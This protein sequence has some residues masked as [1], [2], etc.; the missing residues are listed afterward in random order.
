MDDR[1]AEELEVKLARVRAYMRERGLD[2]LVLRRFDNF[3]WVT[4]GGDNRCAG[5]T[6]VGV[7]SVLVTP[8]DQCVLTSSVEGRRF[9]EEVLA[10]IWAGDVFRMYEY[11]WH[12]E[13]G[14]LMEAADRAL[15]PGGRIGSDVPLAGAE[16]VGPELERLRYPFTRGE[17]ERYVGVARGVAEIVEHAA[18][19]VRPGQTERAIAG[20]V[21]SDLVA[22]GY[23]PTVL[24][25]GADWRVER[26][27]HPLPTMNRVEKYCMIIVCAHRGGLT[28]ALTRSVHI[29]EPG[30]ELR[31]RHEAAAHICAAMNCRTQAGARWADVM[32]AMEEEYRAQGFEGEWRNHHQGGPIGYQDRE[33]LVTPAEVSDWDFGLIRPLQAVAWNPSVPG[34]KSEDSLLVTDAGPEIATFG[35]GWWPMI[36]IEVEGARL[37][38]P[39]ILIV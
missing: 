26:Y 4:A 35:A 12:G 36:D 6:D 29:G 31:R 9:R 39:D 34:A 27:R 32:E 20:H 15:P 23:F 33:F 37:Q 2:A 11:P 21:G 8:D 30:R 14:A 19:E 28:A 22:A 5:A 25:V 7:A 13:T 1:I 18:R 10:H 3:A 38:R 17:A 24:L 16:Y